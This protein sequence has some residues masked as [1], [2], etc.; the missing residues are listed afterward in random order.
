[1][2][3]ENYT[4]ELLNLKGFNVIRTAG[5]VITI[6]LPVKPHI[7]PQC[8]NETR[9]IHDYRLQKV[10]HLPVAHTSYTILIKKRRYKCPH[11]N[12]RFYEKNSLL[13]KYKSISTDLRKS[14]LYYASKLFNT[15]QIADI[16][17]LSYSTVVRIIDSIVVPKP[18]VFPDVISIDEFK[19][20]T[21]GYKFQCVLTDPIKKK[22]IEVLPNKNSEDIYGHLANNDIKNRLK[23]N[24]VI[25]DMSNQFRSIMT[26]CFPNAKVIADKFHVLRL[27]N[28]A[29]EHIRKQEQKRFTDTRRRYFKKSRFILLKRR[30]KLRRNEK[31]QLSHMLSVSALLKKAYILK[32]LFYMVMD[33]KNEKQFYKRIYKWLFLVE[34]Y[35]IDRFLAMAKTVRQW[36]HPIK[37]AILTGY[38]NGYTE[39][40]NNRTKVLKR[41]CFGVRNFKRF[42]NRLM[43][44]ANCKKAAG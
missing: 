15:K 42:R 5:K 37:R 25:M 11:C 23:V 3:K 2:L 9:K 20:N 18:T 29:M 35:G 41:I 24:Y 38:T 30:H 36:L 1:M 12:K 27:A 17:N 43:F 14:V 26:N 39:G 6:C 31:I 33:S 13:S 22:I 8:K 16:C 28:W 19:G 40:C 7:C 21:G 4:I 32:E 34:K 44:I 10:K